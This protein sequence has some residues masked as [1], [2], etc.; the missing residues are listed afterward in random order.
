M[1]AEA[2]AYVVMRHFG[3]DHVASNYLATY[4]VDGEQL[5]DSLQTIS[6]VAK[7]LIAAIEADSVNTEAA[8]TVAS[9]EVGCTRAGIAGR[10]FPAPL[11]LR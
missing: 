6:G 5:R 1:E 9:G 8:E 7:R 2:T 10:P 3:I 11:I 4:N